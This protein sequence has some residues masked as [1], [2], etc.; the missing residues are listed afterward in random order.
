MRMANDA[1]WLMILPDLLTVKEVAALLRLHPNTVYK[2]IHMG[3]LKAHKVGRTW[4]IPKEGLRCLN[5]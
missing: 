5:E 2:L 4:R 3:Q 1:V